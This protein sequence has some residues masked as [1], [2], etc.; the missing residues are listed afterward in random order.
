M[1]STNFLWRESSLPTYKTHSLFFTL[2]DNTFVH[3]IPPR[4]RTSPYTFVECCASATPAGHIK[5]KKPRS[6]SL[7]PERG[8]FNI[9]LRFPFQAPESH[10]CALRSKWYRRPPVVL[11]ARRQA[12]SFQPL[13]LPFALLSWSSTFHLLLSRTHRT[14]ACMGIIRTP[15][16]IV[17]GRNTNFL[18]ATF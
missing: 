17:K 10:I 8:F 7:E 5:T 3:S 2:R 13:L 16:Q 9:R 11:G 15:P 4:S 14:S 12:R 6:N 18:K 1:S